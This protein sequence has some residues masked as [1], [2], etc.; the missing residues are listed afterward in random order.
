M[1]QW[2]KTA[3]LGFMALVLGSSFLSCK[4]KESLPEDKHI[5]VDTL[6]EPSYVPV[7][8]DENKDRDVWQKPKIVIDMLGDLSDKTVVDIGAGTGYFTFRLALKAKKVIAVDIENQFLELIDIFKRNLPGDV[9]Q[10]IE[11]RLA[12]PDNPMLEPGEADIV[13]IINTIGFIHSRDAYLRT[14]LPGL[15][16]GGMVFILDYKMKN[17]PIEIAPPVEDRVPL[18]VIEQELQDAGFVNIV[19]NDTSLDYQYVVFAFKG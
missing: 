5:V 2:K 11:T 19:S 10:R 13:V 18:S 3:I 1:N 14:L 17:L 9:Q 7:S 15:R 16:E 8:Q 12:R 6:A 4:Q